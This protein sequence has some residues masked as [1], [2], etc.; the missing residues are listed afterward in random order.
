MG[1]YGA[2]WGAVGSISGGGMSGLG[3]APGM[4]GGGPK[5]PVRRFESGWLRGASMSSG[6]MQG[7]K[8]GGPKTSSQYA[9][10]NCGCQIQ[11]LE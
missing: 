3:S 1:R 4:Q 6:G 8:R 7:G 2:L 10:S 9:D 5:T 11:S